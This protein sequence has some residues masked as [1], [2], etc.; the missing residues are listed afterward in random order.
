MRSLIKKILKE[1]F[2]WAS[3]VDPLKSFEDYFYGN[4]R[5]NT[6]H[7][8]DSFSPGRWIRRDINWWKN[9]I[10]EVEMSHATFLEEIEELNDMV[11]DLVNPVDGSKKYY[12]L[13]EDVYSFLK[14]S[15][16]LNGKSIFQDLA[17]TI[18]DAYTELGPFA[19]D[20]N[21]TILETLNVFK[22]WL[23]KMESEDRTLHRS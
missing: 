18:F 12:Q 22:Q 8:K 5:M 17:L 4:Y 10:H 14:P 9:W 15:P 16:A 3:Q 2:E 7:I 11:H 20:N 13:S 1:D 23:N 6:S 21:L 19:E